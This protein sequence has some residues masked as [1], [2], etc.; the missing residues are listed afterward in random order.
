[1]TIKQID[2]IVNQLK[3]EKYKEGIE[4]LD[5]IDSWK[6]IK[7]NIKEKN[8]DLYNDLQKLNYNELYNKG[9]IAFAFVILLLQD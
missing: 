4:G 3:D 7:S 6:K 2:N 8:I 9:Y 1:M 5:N